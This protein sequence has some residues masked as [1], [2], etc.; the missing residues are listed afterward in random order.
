MMLIYWRAV[1]RKRTLERIPQRLLDSNE[2][3]FSVIKKEKRKTFACLFRQ[4]IVTVSEE[5]L[6]EF[7]VWCVE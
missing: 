5:H 1:K 2:K 3:A 6:S 7:N 4:H